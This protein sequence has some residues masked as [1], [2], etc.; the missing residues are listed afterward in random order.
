MGY[1]VHN[2]KS[3]RYKNNTFIKKKIRF[4]FEL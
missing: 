3:A 4:R 1:S 2:M